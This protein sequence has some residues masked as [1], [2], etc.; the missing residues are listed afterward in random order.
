[1]KT[2]PF[3]LLLGITMISC[4]VSDS[5]ESGDRPHAFIEGLGVKSNEREKLIVEANKGSVDAALALAEHFVLIEWDDKQAEFW[6]KKAAE[7]GGKRE[8]EIYQAFLETKNEA[9]AEQLK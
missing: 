8:E 9:A 3:V 6:Y 4:T 1:M 2:E 7:N 5:A